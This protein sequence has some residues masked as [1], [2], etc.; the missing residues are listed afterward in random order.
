L[1]RLIFELKF[2]WFKIRILQ[3]ECDDLLSEYE[4]DY[5]KAKRNPYF[6]KN[7]KFVEIDEDVAR[8]FQSPDDI[9]KVLKAI[10][11]SLPK[12]AVAVL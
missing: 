6:R 2:I 3:D 1:K 10:A 12:S 11:N 4:I 8:A 5:S 7:R 9:N